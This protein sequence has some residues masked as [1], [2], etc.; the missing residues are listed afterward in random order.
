MDPG[1]LPALMWRAILNSIPIDELWLT[2]FFVVFF[3]K[4]NRCNTGAVNIFTI[5]MHPK[6]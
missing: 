1:G 4:K 2:F 6:T 3:Q 5:K